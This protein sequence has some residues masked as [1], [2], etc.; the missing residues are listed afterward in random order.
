MIDDI[1]DVDD[2]PVEAATHA[3]STMN[4]SDSKGAQ[5]PETPDIDEIPDMEEELEGE[6][7]EATAAPSKPLVAQASTST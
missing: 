3:V 6:E 1:P 2:G 7:D 5:A 4:I